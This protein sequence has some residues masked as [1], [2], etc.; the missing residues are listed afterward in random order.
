MWECFD[1]GGEWTNPEANFDSTFHSMVTLFTAVTTE[2]WADLMWQ[3]VDTTSRH[4][5]P[6]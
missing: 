4:L 3:G 5:M 1:S 6:T 2:G